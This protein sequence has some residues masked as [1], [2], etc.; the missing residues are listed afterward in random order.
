MWIYCAYCARDGDEEGAGLSCVVDTR[1]SCPDCGR[2]A[3]EI[4]GVA[5]SPLTPE[6]V[7][8]ADEEV[9]EVEEGPL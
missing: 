1:D 5:M 9:E 4:G 3:L 6:A 2:S 8:R 7:E